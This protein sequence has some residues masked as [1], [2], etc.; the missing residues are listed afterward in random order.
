MK[1]IFIHIL[2]SVFSLS[3]CV[4]QPEKSTITIGS[5]PLVN[6]TILALRNSSKQAKLLFRFV[7]EDKGGDDIPT[8]ITQIRLEKGDN[9]SQK[10]LYYL[11]GGITVKNKT[12][13]VG[14]IPKLAYSN[15][16]TS[17]NIPLSK[18]LI[19][20]DGKTEILEI[21]GFLSTHK[22]LSE[23]EQIQLKISQ[24]HGFIV[25]ATG[26]LLEDNL[27]KILES[28]MFT[29][30][31]EATTLQ[32]T[33]IPSAVFLD[34]PF[35][36]QVSAVDA[37]GRTDE[38]YEKNIL[39]AREAGTGTLSSQ[40]KFSQKS[41]GGVVEWKTLA[42]NKAENFT[43][44]AIS[45]GF[46]AIQSPVILAKGS[47]SKLAECTQS[48]MNKTLS[49]L[50]VSEKTAQKV[51]AF[52][53]VDK[54]E[55]DDNRTILNR[56]TFNNANP[57]NCASWKQTI[58]GAVLLKNGKI[59]A[60]TTDITD[61][62]I[63]FKK[64]VVVE[65]KT[66]AEMVLAI[67]CNYNNL[68]DG[69]TLQFA[70]QS[71]DFDWEVAS[72]SS[73]IEPLSVDIISEKIKIEVI[74]SQLDFLKSPIVLPQ[75]DEKYL[76]TIGA[77]D[78]NGNIDTDVN[79]TIQLKSKDLHLEAEMKNGLV[80]IE[81]IKSKGLE[82][83]ALVASSANGLLGAQS[84][85]VS[86]K[87][88]LLYADF[89]NGSLNEWQ[90][91]KAW[92]AS[93]IEPLSG[94]KSLKHNLVQMSGT[95]RIVYDMGMIN[96]K[97]GT[98]VWRCQMKNGAWNPSSS[99]AFYWVLNTN[100]PSLITDGAFVVGVNL[101]GSDDL[102]TL[103]KIEGT[104]PIALIKTP[105]KWTENTLVGIEVSCTERGKWQLA[106]DNDGGFDNLYV[107]G[108]VVDTTLLNGQAYNGVE[109][110]HKTASRAGLF[111]MDDVEV[112]HF[113]TMP[114]IIDLSVKSQEKL[115]LVFSQSMS[116][117]VL[118][119]ENYHLDGKR[120]KTIGEVGEDALYLT[121]E[122]MKSGTHQLNISNLKSKLGKPM[123]DTILSFDYYRKAKAREVIINELMIDCSPAVA[124][125]EFEYLELYN[126]TEESLVLDE[127]KLQ[128]EGVEVSL[129]KNT[130]RAKE[131]LL[132]CAT[133]A[134]EHFQKYG[135]VLG[136][137]FP[138]LPNSGATV[139]LKDEQG[140][141]IDKLS[142]TDLWYRNENKKQ[143]G[144]SLERIDFE[145]PSNSSANWL[146]SEDERGGTPCQRNSVFG[147]VVDNEP[148]KVVRVAPL[149]TLQL[150]VVLSERI[151]TAMITAKSFK[152]SP[153]IGYPQ[154]VIFSDKEVLL[155]LENSLVE[156]QKYELELTNIPDLYGNMLDEEQY[157][158][159]LP[160]SPLQGDIV[161][162]ELLF[163]PVPANVD[164]VELYNRSA[165]TFDLSSLY[166]AKRG[167]KGNLEFVVPMS[168]EVRL[169]APQT[170]VVLTKNTA[171]VGEQYEIKNPEAMVALKNMPNFPD[172]HGIVVVLNKEKE[173]IDE[174]QYDE[175]MHFGLL[176]TKEGVALERI[177][178][179][180]A[181]QQKSNWHSA[182]TVVGYGTPSSH[183]S[184]YRE[185]FK[186]QENWTISP[187]V[188]SP[189][190][191]GLNDVM[192]LDYALAKGGWVANIRVFDT[193]GHLVKQLA[194]NETLEV[195]GVIV[196][197]G[198][199]ESGQ[200]VATGRYIIL[201]ELFDESGSVKQYKRT[202]VLYGKRM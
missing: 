113:K 153:D 115:L 187:K 172:E 173:V 18:P 64:E 24:K 195:D 40:E 31:V 94:G 47:D 29:I 116:R 99:N 103:W 50:S 39:L 22:K 57:T 74:A 36:V 21:F 63:R 142:Y 193:V 165:E 179:D 151:D 77:R 124:L 12:Q 190:N 201:I 51:F 61:N 168:A 34:V 121:V 101:V 71:A 138:V 171:L 114:S 129:P 54:G 65:N 136:G 16:R 122:A 158:F 43:L 58:A 102:L 184:M 125:P 144:W 157:E 130:I 131:Y 106:Y 134:V 53:I 177:N 126:N 107:A 182:A 67:Y 56:I 180:E 149:S 55:K 41:I 202:C 110:R 166:I 60:S 163:N 2:V 38:D 93:A 3:I 42:Y 137:K 194:R 162:N 160:E 200:R 20:A 155:I 96:L 154:Q 192:E 90:N 78:K 32:F 141:E 45:N 17:V 85:T 98:T 197:D 37:L 86:K 191:D 10:Y 82:N 152:V 169:F 183:N 95:S 27:P 189:N 111:W 178:Y 13:T 150:R 14:E 30:E 4:A 80:K 66:T 146:V 91:T 97:G 175:D 198:L 145:A 159:M 89:E 123:Q 83:F 33:K 79:T 11:I 105:L 92:K 118:E 104:K 26:S 49:S 108:A 156:G 133:D 15:A 6:D 117:S 128:V 5:P 147:V 188:F 161:I 164:Y 73:A 44:S 1:S 185:A 84:I 167:D 140:V 119:L 7:I 76:I 196:W 72:G 23:K 69:R 68:K 19:V 127:W 170:F 28:P 88:T 148:P 70:I 52:K 174:L 8:I 87:D 62:K 135:R 109:F 75:R 9:F 59:V 100:S 181:T 46:H 143:G 25:A 186:T 132:L 48:S 35:S 120:V 81:N 139:V 112:F 176:A 199:D